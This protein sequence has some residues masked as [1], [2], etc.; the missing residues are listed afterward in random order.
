MSVTYV[1]HI[2]AARCFPERRTARRLSLMSEVVDVDSKLS[3]APGHISQ[4][5]PPRDDTTT[6]HHDTTPRHSPLLHQQQCDTWVCVCRGG[7]TGA[8]GVNAAYVCDI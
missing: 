1:T 3:T 4:T 8:P 6:R 2:S 7:P 5:S